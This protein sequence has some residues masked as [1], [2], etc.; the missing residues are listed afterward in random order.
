VVVERN[1]PAPPPVTRVPSDVE[2]IYELANNVQSAPNALAEAD[3]IRRLRTW[4][5]AHDMTYTLRAYR[6]SNGQFIDSPSVLR[7]PVRA[8]MEIYRGRERLHQFGF[9]PRD[10]QNLALLGS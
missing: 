2:R 1:S 5:S 10:N 7:E 6:S 4:M 9:V 3:A 8:D